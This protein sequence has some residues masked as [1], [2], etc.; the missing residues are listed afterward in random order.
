MVT[1]W[2]RYRQIAG[3]LIKYGFGIVVE[4]YAPLLIRNRLFRRK[5]A[6]TAPMYRRIR[7]ALEELGPTFIKLGQILSTRREIFPPGLIGELN[8]LTDR[9][10]PLPFSQIRPV[11]EGVTGPL[12]EVFS[13]VDEVPLAAASLAQVHR[14]V[15]KNGRMVALKVQ[16][17]GIA[18]VIETDLDILRSMAR[19]IDARFPDL[20]VYNPRGLVREFSAQIRKELDFVR[21][22]KNADQLRKNM[23]ELSDIRVPRIYWEYSGPT[24]LAMEYIEGV[25][26]DD[27]AGIRALG[28]NPAQIAELTLKAYL[29][30]IFVDGF[31]HGD[32]HPGN[33]IV[34]PKKE[35]AYLDFGIMGVI[36]PERRFA[37]VDLLVGIVENDVNLVVDA[38]KALGVEIAEEDAEGFK[39]E[40][41][42]VFHQYR[43]YEARY[44]D[45]GQLLAESANILRSYHLRVPTTMMLMFKVIMMMSAHGERLDPGF[46]FVRRVGPYLDGI[47]ESRF[48]SEERFRRRMQSAIGVGEDLAAIPHSVNRA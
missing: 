47:A 40:T 19:G 12:E 46:N 38:Y 25:R 17:P 15:L 20:A 41:Y 11:I 7:L 43:T 33:L 6:E 45:I 16:R 2:G 35:L 28:A 39:D 34:T 22:G 9:C 1:R 3:V 4:G 26:I 42:A 37:F 24:L 13:S 8:L 23:R 14:A 36:R 48:F 32:P 44:F 18:E 10:S 31:F 30:Q 27:V 5:E 29:T 21:D